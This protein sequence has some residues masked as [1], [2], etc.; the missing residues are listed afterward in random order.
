VISED[1]VARVR[2][3][4]GE[5]AVASL[6]I[7]LDGFLEVV[8]ALGSPEALRHDFA[9]RVVASAAEWQELALLLKPF[10]DEARQRITAIRAEREDDDLAPTGAACPGCGE[11]RTDELVIN[12]DG[13]V[14]CLTCGRRYQLPGE[15]G[16]S[17]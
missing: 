3:Q 15:E 13:S 17:A 12:D 16:P 6:R 7:D 11:R 1:D 10:R 2:E 8:A 5:F 4:L 14:L 9:P